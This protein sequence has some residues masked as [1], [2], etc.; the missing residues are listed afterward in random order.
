MW[1]LIKRGA[2]LIGL[3]FLAQGCGA[4]YYLDR[5]IAKDPKILDSI[6]LKVDTIIITQKEEIR[7]T[8]ILQKIDTITLERNG[9]RI[10]LRRVYDTIEVDVQC[11]S[12]TIRI[13]KEI[14][15]PQLIYQDKNFDRKYLYLLIIS[16]ILYTFGLIKLLK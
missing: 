7:D 15:V 5:A 2:V 1:K 3:L 9:I 16:I 8:L 6:V 10:D 11:P 12:D 13:S 14:K 4:K